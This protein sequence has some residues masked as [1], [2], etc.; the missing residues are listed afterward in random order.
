M[1]LPSPEE[2]AS[3][4]TSFLPPP[5]ATYPVQSPLSSLPTPDSSLPPSPQSCSYS[6]LNV[7]SAFSSFLNTDM[8][9]QYSS[10]PD[11]LPAPQATATQFDLSSPLS[12]PSSCNVSLASYQVTS[13]GAYL[14]S[15]SCA[16]H[17]P[18]PKTPYSFPSFPDVCPPY[19]PPS[20]DT[21]SPGGIRD[22]LV[23]TEASKVT[24]E[25]SI[26]ETASPQKRKAVMSSEGGGGTKGK[27]QKLSKSAKKE[28]KKEQNKL[29]A[30]RY[31]QRKKEASEEVEEKREELEALN[32]SLWEKVTALTSEISYLKK[33]WQEIQEAKDRKSGS[34]VSQQLCY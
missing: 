28:R 11:I 6:D 9:S 4:I 17:D 31:R 29:A 20:A 27:R 5:E 18:S 14:P 34:P 33:L 32:H 26:S 13:D 16:A 30:L 2:Q 3:D 24:C 12:S 8:D 19:S 22:L 7:V 10:F 23:K 1:L 25:V 15:P 21:V